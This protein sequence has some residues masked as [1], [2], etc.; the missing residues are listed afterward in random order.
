MHACAYTHEEKGM[1][2]S[3]GLRPRSLLNIVR[4]KGCALHTSEHPRHPRALLRIPGPQALEDWQSHKWGKCPLI[5]TFSFQGFRS[6]V[7]IYLVFRLFGWISGRKRQTHPAAANTITAASGSLGSGL[8][9]WDPL[10]G[11]GHKQRAQ[12]VGTSSGHKQ[13][14]EGAPGGATALSHR[15]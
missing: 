13:S 14:S 1:V 10:T 15:R 11:G 9:R 3:A 7:F 12:A 4:G 2:M 6:T 8:P 5:N